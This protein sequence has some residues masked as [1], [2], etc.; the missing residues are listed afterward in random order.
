MA[1]FWLDVADMSAGC[2]PVERSVARNLMRTG[3]AVVTKTILTVD[4]SASVLQMVKLTL[5][6]AGYQVV[7][8]A[9]GAD[10]LAKARSTPVDMVIT[11]LNMPIM[12]GLALICALRKLPA[13]KGVPI[14]FLTTESEA[15]MKQQAKAAGATGWITKPFQQDQLV[16]VA[17]KLLGA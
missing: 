17:R 15:T 9:N 5:V 3:H 1:V 2:R 7:Q 13:F 12:D 14:V 8:A 16:A 4:D 6:G 10:G 11:D